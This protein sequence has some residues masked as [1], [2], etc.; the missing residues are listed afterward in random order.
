MHPGPDVPR[1][2]RLARGRLPSSAPAVPAAAPP[3]RPAAAPRDGRHAGPALPADSVARAHGTRRG[4]RAAGGGPAR[5]GARCG[6]GTGRKRDVHRDFLLFL[7]QGDY[8][9]D[10]GGV[11]VIAMV[12]LL[13]LW[14]YPCLD[15]FT[16]FSLFYFYV[17]LHVSLRIA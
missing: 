10:C 14:K 3:A 5:S 16:H 13:V 11:F 9:C 8:F 7:A 15:V 12:E 17:I 4:W 2:A 1:G 6:G